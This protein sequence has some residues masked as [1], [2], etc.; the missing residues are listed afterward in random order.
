MKLGIASRMISPEHYPILDFWFYE[1][2]VNVVPVDS[3]SKSTT[4]R[5]AAEQN[6]GM[7][8]QEFQKIRQTATSSWRSP[9]I[10]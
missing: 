10:R 2:G 6:E 4:N 8:S 3:R 5:W 7:K 1:V 9:L